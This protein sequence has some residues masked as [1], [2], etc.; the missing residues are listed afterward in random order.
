MNLRHLQVF[1]SVVETGSFSGAADKVLLTQ[2]T[3]SQHIAALEGELGVLLFDR[4]GR[5]AEPTEGGQLF[6]CHVQRVLDEYA[7]LQ[8][9][10]A[11]YRGVE[12]LQLTIGASNIPMDDLIPELLPVLADRYPGLV[13][14]VLAGDSRDMV[15]Q[16]QSGALALAVVG[17]HYPDHDVDFA[18]LLR[19]RM[20]L[21]VGRGH[22]WRE[23]QSLD[24]DALSAGALI[25]REPG[26]GSGHAVDAA[27]HAA[28]LDPARLKIVARLG[29]NQ[30]VKQ[31]VIG[32]FG[33][34]FLS[35]RS[36][37]RERACGDLQVVA[38]DGVSIVRRFWLATRRGRS[39]SPAAQAL[40]SVLFEVFGAQPPGPEN[41]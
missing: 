19:D 16:L 32:G 3:V 37:R 18:P 38:L 2:S 30:A 17:A 27:L 8:Q 34:A 29:T 20:M 1:A 9:A 28:G 33:A 31:A 4:T 25:A 24:L 23:R 21:V 35:A 22:P 39:L 6:A 26:S 36:I 41:C 40:V 10:M 13:L 11:R 14:N 5:G 15:K 12:D 7:Q